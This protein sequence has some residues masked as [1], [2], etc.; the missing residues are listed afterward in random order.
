M[1]NRNNNLRQAIN[2]GIKTS[3]YSK[4]NNCIVTFFC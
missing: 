1:G 2:I 3:I 4:L